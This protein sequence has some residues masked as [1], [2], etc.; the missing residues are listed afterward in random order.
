MTFKVDG[1]TIAV[2]SPPPGGYGY[3]S[4]FTGRQDNPWGGGTK[5]APFDREVNIQMYCN[6]HSNVSLYARKHISCSAVMITAVILYGT[7]L[8]FFLYGCQT[9]SLTLREDHRS[10][11]SENRMLRRMFGH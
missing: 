9:L 10:K 6:M 3:L 4:A 8:P 11:K 1:Q 7:T 5:L 2:L